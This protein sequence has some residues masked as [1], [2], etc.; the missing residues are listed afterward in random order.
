MSDDLISAAS[1]LFVLFL[2]GFSFG[3]IIYALKRFFEQ[4]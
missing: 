1:F 4:I 2:A 3:F